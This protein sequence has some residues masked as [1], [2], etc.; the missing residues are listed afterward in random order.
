MKINMIVAYCANKGIGIHNKLPWCFKKDLRYF[1]KH[2]IGKKNNAIVMG[3]NT[4]KSIGSYPLKDRYNYILTRNNSVFNDDFNSKLVSSINECI[5]DAKTKQYNE[6]WVIGGSTI[7]EQFL[8][9]DLIDDIY[10]TYIPRIYTCDKYFSGIPNH[11]RMISNEIKKENGV[12][13][14]FQ[15]YRS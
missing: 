1:A 5:E 2:T 8:N 7:Y 3:S 14:Q 10:V 9:V 4:W 15:V 12:P 13:L 6:L 11:F